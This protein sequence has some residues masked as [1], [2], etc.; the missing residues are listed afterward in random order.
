[1][2][3]Q[4]QFEK[5]QAM[6]SAASLAVLALI[7]ALAVLPAQ[8]EDC[9]VE[10]NAMDDI[11]G[12][13]KQAP[14]CDRA[15]KIF[16]ACEFGTSADI[17]FGAVVEQKCEADFLAGLKTAR[18][19]AYRHDLGVCDR[20]YQHESGTMYRS[21]TAFCRAE[22]SQRYSQRASKTAGPSQAR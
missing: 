21:F 17:H 18:K 1:V 2:F 3:H 11:I 22:V 12:A 5:E 6:R 14:N 9:P 8:A 15:M 19:Q 20:K 16:R 10:S 7:S 13:L 4:G